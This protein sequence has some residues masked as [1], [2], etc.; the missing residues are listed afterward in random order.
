VT[1]IPEPSD[2]EAVAAILAVLSARSDAPAEPRPLRE[3]LS[4]WVASG[5]AEQQLSR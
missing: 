4:P 5:W 1:D 3:P 2:E